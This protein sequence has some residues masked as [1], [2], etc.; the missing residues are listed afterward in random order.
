ME[1][2]IRKIIL[3]CLL[4]IAW[5][6]SPML[7]AENKQETSCFPTL[8]DKAEIYLVTCGPGNDFYTTFG[9]TAIRICDSTMKIDDRGNNLDIVFNYGTFDFNTK[10]FYYKFAKGQLSYYLSIDD[11]YSFLESYRREGR[12]VY[13]QQLNLTK[14]EKQRLFELLLTNYRPENRYYKYDFF[15][16]NCATRVRDI[17][18]KSLNGRI[19][20]KNSTLNPKNS[21]RKQLRPYMSGV[22]EW[23]NL[24][25]DLALGRPCDRKTSPW[26][27]NFLPFALMQQTDTNKCKNIGRTC[28]END[29]TEFGS[30]V[31]FAGESLGSK[32]QLIVKENKD[33][34]SRSIS[35]LLVF[36]LVLFA[37]LIITIAEIK[38]KLPAIVSGVSDQILFGFVGIVSLPLLFLWFFSDHYCTQWNFNLLWINPLLLWVCFKINKSP[39]WLLYTIWGCLIAGLVCF[40][41][42]WPQTLPNASLPIIITLMLRIWM[43]I[44]R[45]KINIKTQ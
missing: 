31:F 23:W 30:S 32:P 39:Q 10:N 7:K 21:Y 36:Y 14:P 12:A 42:H 40:L 33:D 1:K 25:I 13:I 11:Y 2:Q 41:L 18:E 28:S 20:Y 6:Y 8:S 17:I 45:K 44:I 26:D 38:Q 24:G 19:C 34:I 15:I 35:P 29:S 3:T 37:Y 43:R 5:L 16:D 9:H 27:E 4:A 22:L